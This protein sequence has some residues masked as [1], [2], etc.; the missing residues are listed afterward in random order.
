MI[1]FFVRPSFALIHEER[2]IRCAFVRCILFET[3]EEV[4]TITFFFEDEL[5]V[6]SRKRSN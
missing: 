3:V 6:G 2:M 1:N 4:D 5:E